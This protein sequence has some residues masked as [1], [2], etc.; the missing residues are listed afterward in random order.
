MELGH[1]CQKMVLNPKYEDMNEG[2]H[3]RFFFTLIF[4]LYGN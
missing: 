3:F 4:I 2:L 1:N